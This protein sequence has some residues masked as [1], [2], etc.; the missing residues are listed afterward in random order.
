MIVDAEG[1]DDLVNQHDEMQNT[2][3]QVLAPPRSQGGGRMGAHVPP[4]N[5]PRAGS[6]HHC[7][8]DHPGPTSLDR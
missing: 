7:P 2:H 6:P 5:M 8:T 3:V 1:H 4:L